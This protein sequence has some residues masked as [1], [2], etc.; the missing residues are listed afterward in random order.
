MLGFMAVLMLWKV[1]CCADGDDQGSS[2]SFPQQEKLSDCQYTKTKEITFELT[3][4]L[5]VVDAH[6]GP[7]ILPTS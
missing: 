3:I 6:A 7:P 2:D 4:E 5:L 1:I